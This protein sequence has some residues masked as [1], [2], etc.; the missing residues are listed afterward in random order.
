MRSPNRSHAAAHVAS[1]IDSALRRRGFTLVEFTLAAGLSAVLLLGVGSA[2]VISA[3][4]LPAD[5][6]GLSA[7]DTT[8]STLERITTE[9][10]YATE[11]LQ[12]QSG[13]IEFLVPDQDSDGAEEAISYS[14][15]NG[16]TVVRIL[17]GKAPATILTNVESF[18][19]SAGTI[20]VPD[21]E[22]PPTST[23]RL[24][25]G[26]DGGT[27]T[28][29]ALT[30]SRQVAQIFRPTLAAGEQSWRATRALIKLAQSGSIDGSTFVD[31]RGSTSATPLSVPGTSTSIP[32][33]SLSAT[34][35]WFEVSF[36]STQWV[37]ASADLA[38]V[39]RR[40]T[41]TASA[42]VVEASNV[43][44]TNGSIS[45]NNGSAW[46]T[47]S[48]SEMAIQI[49]GQVSVQTALAANAGSVFGTP[50]QDQPDGATGG[51]TL[52]TRIDITLKTQKSATLRSTAILTNQPEQP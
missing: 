42:A 11:I 23:E 50:G 40:S 38:I 18:T 43:Q 49:F 17:N 34:P 21:P 3:R 33:S 24:L 28:L 20:F 46:T 27:P 41:G 10:A 44:L 1:P 13:K 47:S 45:A 39:L 9:L 30:G 5:A 7:A 22:P 36:G 16:N 29:L 25:F 51:E 12:I 26:C 2:F 37:S 15:E 14:L 31:L 19:M 8:T 4:A 52:V 35:G 6:A 32:E 48:T